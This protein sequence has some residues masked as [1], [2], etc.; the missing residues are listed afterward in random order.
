LVAL[1]RTKPDMQLKKQ[2]TAI[3]ESFL[4]FKEQ[5]PAG[6]WVSLIDDAQ[7]LWF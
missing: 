4:V 3:F 7:H 5:E 6:L 2:A 1:Y